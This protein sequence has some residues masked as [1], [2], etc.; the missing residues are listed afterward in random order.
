[1]Q[2]VEVQLAEVVD[3]L[4]R[5]GEQEPRGADARAVA[6]RTDVLDHHLVEPG[7]HLG[8]GFAA[9]TVAAIVPLD[10]SRD[11]AESHFL[12][13]PV[14]TLDFC[15]R[16]RGQHDLLRVDPVQDRSAHAVGQIGPARL[17]RKA[18]G[19]REAVHHPAIPGVRVVPE[20]LLHEAAA[21][22]AAL[23]IG[24]E[25]LGMRELVHAKTATRP[26]GA[27]GIVE[28]KELGCD[29]AVHEVM[30][31]AAQRAVEALGV[32]LARPLHDLNLQ[33]AVA[34][35]QGAGDGSLDRFLVLPADHEAIDNRVH[36]L[37]RRFVQIDLSRDVHQLARR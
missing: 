35:E 13:F 37:D 28:D 11:P 3:G 10:P 18:Q 5:D 30:G 26:A 7:L 34:D 8:A 19:L 1:M 22:D 25:E 29:P 20:R 12:P 14:V 16:R 32:G 2:L 31:R 15:F 23:R 6:V 17:E 27:L 24:D 9:L 21:D 4:A 36:V 33:E